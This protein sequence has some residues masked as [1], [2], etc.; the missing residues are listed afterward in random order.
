[1]CGRRNKEEISKFSV[2]DAENYEKY[3][4]ELEQFVKAVDSLLGKSIK[5][6]KV[7][8]GF[9]ARACPCT[10]HTRHFSLFN[11]QNG[12][13]CAPGPPIASSLILPAALMTYRE[14][15]AKTHLSTFYFYFLSFKKVSNS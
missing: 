12:S 9:A 15:P 4:E 3:E 7:L 13:L 1:M 6:S 8:M 11:T 10:A 5:H 2:R 14:N